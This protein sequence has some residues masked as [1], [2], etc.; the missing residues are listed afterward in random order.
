MLQAG[1]RWVSSW[2]LWRVHQR[3]WL[4]AS[5]SAMRYIHVRKAGLAVKAANAPEHLDEDFL[6]DIRG[7]CRVLKTAS[8]QGVNR[9]GVLRDEQTECFFRACF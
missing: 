2:R 9:L 4:E 8:D 1:C 7:V 3:L 6:R 5:C